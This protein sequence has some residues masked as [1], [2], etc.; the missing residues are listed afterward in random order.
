[1]TSIAHDTQL[2]GGHAGWSDKNRGKF[3]LFWAGIGGVLLIAMACT[4]GASQSNY[5]PND[6]GDLTAERYLPPSW[7]H[8][9]GTDKFSRD[10]FSR[11]LY[12]GRISLSIAF[13]VVLLTL[14]LGIM[15]GSVSGYLGG[16]T[17]AVMMRSLDF[18]LAFPA[19]F[20]I[21]MLVAVFDMN[22]WYLIPILALTGWM[23]SA[24]LVRAEV[25]SL[26]ERE[27]ILAARTLGFGH[28]R[29]L[30]KHIIPNS[31][32]P[33]LVAATFKIGEVILL[34]SALSFLG[35]GIQPP[36]A[37]WGNI[38]SDGR[39]VL[40][41]AWWIATCPGFFIV[42]TVLSTNL[43]AEGLRGLLSLDRSGS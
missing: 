25:L 33:V 9:F 42:L 14:T 24:R 40:F 15:Y 22:H 35:I 23:E 36:A 17:D 28:A 31:M 7:E 4:I 5:A 34:E 41:R 21:I 13:S 32:T 37:S 2:I 6:Q 19:V 12:G 11:V 29:I 1:M 30:F 20:L 16:T 39:D 43:I 3:Y 10:V 26:K 18:L 27:F 38:I 8:P